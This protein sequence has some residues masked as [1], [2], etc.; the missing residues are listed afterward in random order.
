MVHVIYDYN[1]AGLSDAAQE[2]G[3]FYEGFRFQR[4]FG[5]AYCH[6]QTGRGVLGIFSRALRQLV[7]LV[8]RALPF[9]K[10]YLAPLAKDAVK[11]IA[12]E[13][14]EAGQNALSNIAKGQDVRGAVVTEGTQVLKKLAKRAGA[15][16]Q[17][18]S[19]TG[20]RGGGGGVKKKKA[21][22]KKKLVPVR[23]AA[24]ANLVGR[25]VLESAAK[26]KRLRHTQG[27]Y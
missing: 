20:R 21:A 15:R 12:E 4:G 8:R 10:Q 26:Q 17:E 14:L 25:S 2:G 16:L 3:S 18:Q 22:P 27:L 13:G 5:Y 11:A 6:Q 1:S 7:P 24:Y 9:A 19:G 23:S